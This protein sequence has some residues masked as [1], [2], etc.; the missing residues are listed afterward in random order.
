MRRVK[1]IKRAQALGFT[2]EETRSLL[3]FEQAH[4]FCDTKD[5]AVHKIQ[6]IGERIADLRRMRKTLSPY[7]SENNCFEAV[8]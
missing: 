5:L 3:S 8:L 1:F 6:K 7:S 4:S 2:L